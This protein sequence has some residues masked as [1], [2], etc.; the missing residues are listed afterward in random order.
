MAKSLMSLETK[1]RLKIFIYGDMGTG[2]TFSIHTFP[3]PVYIFDLDEGVSTLRGVVGEDFEYNVFTDENPKR[4]S[5]YVAFQKKVAE[6][7]KSC[8]YATVVLDSV[9]ALGEKLIPNAV[10]GVQGD[11]DNPLQ[12]QDHL[13]INDKLG[14]AIDDLLGIDAHVVV[15]SHPKVIQDETTSEIKFLIMMTGQKLPQKMP[16]YFDEIYKADKKWNNKKGEFEYVWVTRGDRKWPS[17][18]RFNHRDGK[19]QIKPILN[20]E[21]PQNLSLILEKVGEARDK[22]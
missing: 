16:L 12:L 21:E 9:T 6:L 15:M 1:D 19:G 18:S 4:P 3:T 17:R 10:R 7:R 20:K 8:K 22:I 11:W 13:K 2:K 14:L 5:G